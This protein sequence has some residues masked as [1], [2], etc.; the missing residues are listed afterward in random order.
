MNPFVYDDSLAWD[1][2]E[3][4]GDSWNRPGG[5]LKRPLTAD[6]QADL[7]SDANRHPTPV[8]GACFIPHASRNKMLGNEPIK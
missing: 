2:A 7:D 4:S 1:Q 8:R 5:Y 6:E 3:A